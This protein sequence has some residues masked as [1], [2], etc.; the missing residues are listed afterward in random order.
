M[1]QATAT[2]QAPWHVVPADHKWFTRLVVS[3]AV[4]EGLE[5]LGL[6]YPEVDPEKRRELERVRAALVGEKG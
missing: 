3:Q 1:V 2:K 4:V 6:H 5:K